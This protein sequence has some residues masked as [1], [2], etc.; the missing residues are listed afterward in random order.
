MRDSHVDLLGQLYDA[1]TAAGATADCVRLQ[2]D[3]AVAVPASA[4]AQLRGRVLYD[5]A[6]LYCRDGR[7]DDARDTL[8]EA[9]RIAPV[10][11]ASAPAD[12]DLAPLFAGS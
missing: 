6:C 11:A 8:A 3:V 1:L 7:T 4:S 5:L 12:A 9:V 10:L 2:E